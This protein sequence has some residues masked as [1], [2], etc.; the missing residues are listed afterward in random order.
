VWH[1]SII[2][3]CAAVFKGVSADVPE[4]AQGSIIGLEH[5]VDFEFCAAVFKGVSGWGLC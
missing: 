5:N 3:F 2:E 1:N 4:V